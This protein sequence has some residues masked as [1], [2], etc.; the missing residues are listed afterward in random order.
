LLVAGHSDA[1]LY[2]Q[3][4]GWL[5]EEGCKVKANLGNLMRLSQK[6][7]KRELEMVTQW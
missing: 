1:L 6:Q 3:L 7:I 5:S 4:L 2:S